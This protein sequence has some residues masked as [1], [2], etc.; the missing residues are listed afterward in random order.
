M[1]LLKDNFRAAVTCILVMCFTFLIY[2]DKVTFEQAITS[3]TAV[4][5]GYFFTKKQEAERRADRE[6]RRANEAENKLKANKV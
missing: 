5:S 3:I 4:A 6:S 1:N 2:A